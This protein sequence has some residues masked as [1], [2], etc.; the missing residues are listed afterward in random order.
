MSYRT[1]HTGPYA[2][3]LCHVWAD[4]SLTPCAPVDSAHQA[5]AVA[6]P[7][8]VATSTTTGIEAGEIPGYDTRGS[9]AKLATTLEQNGFSDPWGRA[10]RAALD[11]DRG[12]RAGTITRAM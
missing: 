8:V 7:E 3:R 12:V 4:G 6:L 11:W 5:P 10:R 2:G 1:P 9:I